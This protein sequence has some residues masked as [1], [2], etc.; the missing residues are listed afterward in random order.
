MLE[1]LEFERLAAPESRVHGVALETGPL[2]SGL[3]AY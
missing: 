2:A 1:V 3:H